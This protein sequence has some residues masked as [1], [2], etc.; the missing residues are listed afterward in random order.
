M[1]R[2]A[3]QAIVHG[4]AKSQTHYATNFHF[5]RFLEESLEEN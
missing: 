5:H 1:D 2:G 3:E 4:I